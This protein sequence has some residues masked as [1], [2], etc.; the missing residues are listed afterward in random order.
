MIYILVPLG[1]VYFLVGLLW[2]L[3][4]SNAGKLKPTIR[5]EVIMMI[6]FLPF[7]II[8]LTSHVLSYFFTKLM[9]SIVESK[10]WN[11]KL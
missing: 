2:T 9:D 4:I 3:E 1:F 8:V 6:L 7:T 10:W 11:K 5:G